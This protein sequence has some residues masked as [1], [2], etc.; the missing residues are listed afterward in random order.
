[1]TTSSEP[2]VLGI[3]PGLRVCGW[4]IVRGGQRAGYIACGAIKPNPKAP[5]TTRLL[6]LY[7]GIRDIII[8]HNPDEMAIEDP[9]VGTIQPASALAICLL[10]T[11]PSPRD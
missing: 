11:S 9:F 2:T 4:G 10:Y 8:T 5:M 7:D 6:A 1:M 3:D